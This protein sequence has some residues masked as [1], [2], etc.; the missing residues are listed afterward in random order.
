LRLRIVRTEGDSWSVVVDYRLP[1]AGFAH[2]FGA[3]T[4]AIRDMLLNLAQTENAPA[5]VIDWINSIQ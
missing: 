5:A 1:G 3:K 2:D 4:P